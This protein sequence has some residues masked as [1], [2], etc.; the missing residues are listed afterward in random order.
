[1]TKAE[2]KLRKAMRQLNKACAEVCAERGIE[3]TGRYSACRI[4]HKGEDTY[5]NVFGYD[6]HGSAYTFYQ[7]ED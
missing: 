5:Y 7:K 2:K 3:Y 6:P 4:P 1:M